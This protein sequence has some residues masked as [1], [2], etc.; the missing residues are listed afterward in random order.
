MK[1][2]IRLTLLASDPQTTETW[3]AQLWALGFLQPPLPQSTLPPTSLTPPATPEQVFDFA[4]ELQ[5]PIS[6][7]A[8]LLRP[9]AA[10]SPANG[11]SDATP[12]LLSSAASVWEVVLVDGHSAQARELL[13]QSV[14]SPQAV[15]LWVLSEA[16]P[17]A[18][19]FARFGI[20]F[21]QVLSDPFRKLEVLAKLQSFERLRLWD[22]VQTANATMAKLIHRLQ[23]D[24]MVI[25]KLQASQLQNRFADI[26][27][28]RIDYRYLAGLKSGGDYFDLAESSDRKTLSLL[29]S[30]ASSYGLSS[31]VLEAFLKVSG[32]LTAR[33]MA[34]S[35]SVVELVKK[36]S[37][38][39]SASLKQ[40]DCVSLLVGHLTRETQTL[41][42]LNLGSAELF[43]AEPGSRF[44]KLI[45]HAPAVSQPLQFGELQESLLVLKKGSRLVILSAG[46]L[47][48]LG[49]EL[50]RLE[51]ME[52][53]RNRQPAHL[54]N[55]LIFLVKS[56]LPA[57]EL[58]AR[59]CTAVVVDLPF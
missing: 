59:D 27:D 41:S 12:T 33:K 35:G 25:E 48:P 8:S 30:N 39:L 37:E 20:S 52:K 58:P 19:V 9:T 34:Q 47:V 1:K 38:L 4:I 56:P 44:V 29:M 53:W 10:L 7:G 2:T 3:E 40:P 11:E 36:V 49:H 51:W 18:A 31:R 5:A 6:R 14:I 43:Y 26:P 45:Q 54:L 32:Q 22:E 17:Y 21:D 46:F 28:F 55:E 24:L 42:F 13:A 23:E 15:V 16:K 50:D 57:D